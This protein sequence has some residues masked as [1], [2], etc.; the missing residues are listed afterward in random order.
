MAHPLW[1]PRWLL[2]VLGVVL[3]TSALIAPSLLYRSIRVN[4]AALMTLQGDLVTQL[5]QSVATQ[6]AMLDT[7]GQLYQQQE[8]YLTLLVRLT[9]LEQR[10]QHLTEQ[11]TLALYHLI[12]TAEAAVYVASL[13][14]E[15]K[16][17]MSPPTSWY[18]WLKDAQDTEE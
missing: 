13:T 17:V 11:N 3:L 8:R 4:S 18:K 9:D 1:F 10:I 2:P 15:Q 12:R 14:S 7:M 6:Q 5:H 16:P